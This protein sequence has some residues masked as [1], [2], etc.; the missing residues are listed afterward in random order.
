MV[1]I[2]YLQREYYK[3]LKSNVNKPSYFEISVPPLLSAALQLALQF[4]A[5][6]LNKCWEY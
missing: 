2:F 5:W 4:K 1:V 3:V 6:K